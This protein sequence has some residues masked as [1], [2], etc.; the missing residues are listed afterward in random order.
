M[1]A[2]ILRV[3]TF[4]NPTSSVVDSKSHPQYFICRCAAGRNVT[5]L[6]GTRLKLPI[7][8][9]TDAVSLLPTL[10]Y[11]HHAPAGETTVCSTNSLTHSPPGTSCSNGRGVWVRN[12]SSTMVCQIRKFREMGFRLRLGVEEYRGEKFEG[13]KCV[14]SLHLSWTPV[15]ISWGVVSRIG[16]M[17]THT[18]DSITHTLAPTQKIIPRHSLIHVFLLPELGS[19]MV[20]KFDH[21]PTFRLFHEG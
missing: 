18:L 9:D 3:F 15:Y 12:F 8:H 21:D 19:R 13:L 16:R 20:V 4:V 11:I 2:R 1:G 10:L 14:L 6:C 17:T 7:A 5:S